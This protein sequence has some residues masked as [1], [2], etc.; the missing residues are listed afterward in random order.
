M[1]RVDSSDYI[2]MKRLQAKQN[3][4]TAVSPL[5]FRA[6]SLYTN[7]WVGATGG[8]FLPS[9]TNTHNLSAARHVSAD[10]PK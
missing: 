7:V 4:S 2:R 1:Q 6:K 8:Y 9:V 5:K 3:D 10:L